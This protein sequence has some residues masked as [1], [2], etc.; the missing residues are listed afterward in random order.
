MARRAATSGAKGGKHLKR[1]AVGLHGVPRR[2]PAPVGADKA[3]RPVNTLAASGP[4]ATRPVRPMRLAVGIAQQAHAK[5]V[6][7]PE[8]LMRGGVVLRDAEHGHAEHLEL[9][10]VVGELAGLGRAARRVVLWVEV[11]DIPLPLEVLC[12]AD[13]AFFVVQRERR[14]LVAGL[15]LHDEEGTRKQSR[16]TREDSASART[17]SGTPRN[18]SRT[19]PSSRRRRRRMP[20]ATPDLFPPARTNRGWWRGLFGPA[21]GPRPRSEEH[22]S[23]LQSPMYLVCRLLLEKKNF[24]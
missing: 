22:T 18:V 9:R 2:L 6:L 11:D 17:R 5:A 4:F 10:E 14:G 12:G 21:A 23:E 7:L 1:V 15:E 20:R 3:G 13:V 19:R 8:R 16:T 24:S